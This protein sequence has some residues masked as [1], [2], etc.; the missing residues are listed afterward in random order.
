MDWLR[1]LQRSF[2]S[3][4]T[5]GDGQVMP[6]LAA[7]RHISRDLGLSI[8]ANAYRARLR[9]ALENDHG[10]LARYLGDDLWDRLCADFVSACPSRYTSLRN[11]GDALPGFLADSAPFVQ[12]P[13]I[14]EL[15]TFERRLLDC[16]DAEEASLASWAEL[17]AL[18]AGDWPGLRLRFHPS[19]HR[20][21]TEWN[22]V[23]LWKALKAE[24]PPPA[25]SAGP[26]VEWV[27]WRDGE[28]VTRFRPLDD[29][30][31]MAVDRMLAGDTFASLCETLLRWREPEA[32]PAFAVQLLQRW[33]EEGWVA[34]WIAKSAVATA[35]SLSK[36][37]HGNLAGAEKLG[38]GA[39][40]N[41]RPDA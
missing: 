18:P 23:D 25:A 24:Q 27:L 38:G 31:A 15:A 5:A 4:V 2:Q 11:F 40:Q 13:Q 22:S 12:H 39:A 3:S 30:E 29:E 41:H 8:Y 20:H 21:R 35:D 6:H 14:S 1:D 26:G 37:Q 7:D 9:E 33:A 17:Q 19:L 32:V 36:Q 10:I 16:F 34:Q 28:L